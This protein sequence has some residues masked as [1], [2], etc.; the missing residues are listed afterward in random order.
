MV[1]QMPITLW[2]GTASRPLFAPLLS[3]PRLVRRKLWPEGRRRLE[4]A[5]AH[6]RP[7]SATPARALHPGHPHCSARR[8]GLAAAPRSC[9]QC[10]PG[11]YA[12]GSPAF[13]S[14]EGVPLLTPG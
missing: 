5:P 8:W 3:R 10:D 2:S 9:G 1:A 6:S 14:A 13:P 7:G 11:S 4:L 12:G